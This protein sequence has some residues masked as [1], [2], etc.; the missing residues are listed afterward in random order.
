MENLHS[1]KNWRRSC[2]V[3]MWQ[4]WFLIW[5]WKDPC[6]S[7][8]HGRAEDGA[9]GSVQAGSNQERKIKEGDWE[10]ERACKDESRFFA[11]KTETGAPAGP[12]RQTSFCLERKLGKCQRFSNSLAQKNVSTNTQPN[13]TDTT[14][15]N[16]AEKPGM[17]LPRE[18]RLNGVKNT[19]NS[20]SLKSER[21]RKYLWTLAWKSF[22]FL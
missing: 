19:L 16:S 21:P 15:G 12:G 20:Q 10:S 17:H 7:F 8:S 1:G 9:D 5:S 14:Q 11:S 18:K 3:I 2:W 13:F 22:D 6:W 4:R